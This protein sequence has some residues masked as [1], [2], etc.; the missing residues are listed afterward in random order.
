MTTLED[1]TK[2]RVEPSAEQESAVEL[3]RGWP[4]NRACR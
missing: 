4:R 2:K 1:M 3:V